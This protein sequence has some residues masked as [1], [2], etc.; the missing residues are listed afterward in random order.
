[1][2]SEEYGSAARF[3]MRDGYGVSTRMNTAI[4]NLVSHI[5]SSFDEMS[6]AVCCEWRLAI[7]TQKALFRSDA[8]N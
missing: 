1:M 3:R 4:R 6:V 8:A 2:S 7:L 5:K